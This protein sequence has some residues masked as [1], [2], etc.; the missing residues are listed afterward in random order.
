VV[1]DPDAAI[2]L[3]SHAADLRH[4]LAQEHPEWM[5][6]LARTPHTD[7]ALTREDRGRRQLVSA[8]GFAWPARPG[9]LRGSGHGTI[10]LVTDV[11]RLYAAQRS[12]ALRSEA[13]QAA[14]LLAAAALLLLAMDRLV[15][16]PLATLRRAAARLGHGQLDHRVPEAGARELSALGRSLNRMGESLQASAKRMSDSEQRFRDLTASAPDAIVT[17]DVEGRIDQFNLAAEQ[18]FGHA[19][20]QVK[21]HPLDCLLPEGA[22]AVHAGH[23]AAFANEGV[24]ASRRMNAGRLVM[25]RHS[26]G[27]SLQLEIGISRS[28]V[29][30]QISFTAVIRDVSERV[31]IE[32]ELETHRRHLEDLVQSRTAELLLER[33]RTQAATRAKSEFLAN[34]D[35]EIRTPLNAII[36]LA[37]VAA[38]DAEPKAAMHLKRIE[39]AAQ[40]LRALIGDVLDFTRIEAGRMS[41]LVADAELWSMVHTVCKPLAAQAAAHGVELLE[42]IDAD[43]PA[44]VKVDELRLRHVIGHLVGNAVKFT[45]TGHVLVR[46]RPGQAPGSLLFEVSDTGIGVMPEV[47]QRL[48]RPFEHD[49]E[50]DAKRF[51]RAGLGLVISQRLLRLMGS[52]LQARSSVGEGATFWFEL[53]GVLQAMPQGDAAPPAP[54]ARRVLVVDERLVAAQAAVEVL[55]AIGYSPSMA[56]SADEAVAVVQQAQAEGHPFELCLI[57]AGQVRPKSQESGRCTGFEIGRR[58]DALGL[59]QPPARMLTAREGTPVLL[60]EV[61][62]QGFMGVLHK[63]L[64]PVPTERRLALHALPPDGSWV[65]PSGGPSGGT[66]GGTSGGQP[67]AAAGMAAPFG[68]AD[69]Q[70]FANAHRHDGRR[71]RYLATQG[72][73]EEVRAMAYALQLAAAAMGAVAVEAAAAALQGEAQSRE[74][75]IQGCDVLVSA[76]EIQLRDIDIEPMAAQE[77]ATPAVPLDAQALRGLLPGLLARRDMSAWRVVQEHGPAV[78]AAFGST[79]DALIQAVSDFDFDTAMALL[80]QEAGSRAL[81][82]D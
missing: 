51:G 36:G 81:T 10:F 76:L 27:R 28:A 33:D 8:R 52:S 68:G 21:G 79:A 19:A 46:V 35:H 82:P 61:I 20:E 45:S 29:G 49:D 50:I 64:A 62:R 6:L 9:E 30:G 38:R 41:I 17:L 12:A 48:F 78:R 40:E 22:A 16:R 13:S 65:G 60:S 15:L 2:H 57:D 80:D 24:S 67:S 31:A 59:V 26:D 44:L 75:M 18:L 3:T 55:R 5:D 66:S 43:L 23:L 14:V 54:A 34:M 7:Q 63:P 77:A 1:V 39:S 74:V 56:G 58:I 69:W 53:P 11:E 25:G 42:W 70:A 47:L 37:H 4:P 32:A 72:H 71:L 73:A